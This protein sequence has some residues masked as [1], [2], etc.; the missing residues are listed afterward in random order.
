MREIEVRAWCPSLKAFLPLAREVAFIDDEGKLRSRVEGIIFNEYTGLKDKHGHKIYE[1]D[2]V[3]TPDDP[4]YSGP[5][6]FGVVELNYA[7]EYDITMNCFYVDTP[8]DST[9][10]YVTEEMCSGKVQILGNIYEHPK[11]LQKD[12]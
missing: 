1:G 5:V 4:N 9:R 2:I 8:L 10:E 6:R 7:G 3:G 12:V 11:L